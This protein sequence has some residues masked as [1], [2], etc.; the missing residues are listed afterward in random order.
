MIFGYN[1]HELIGKNVNVL[2][3]EQFRTRHNEILERVMGTG[4]FLRKVPEILSYGMNSNKEPIKLKIL[5]SMEIT[6]NSEIQITG[7]LTPAN[8][9]DES[10]YMLTDKDG[11][12]THVSA[13]L[14]T[15][16]NI[17][18]RHLQNRSFNIGY[19]N[20]LL[21]ENLPVAPIIFQKKIKIY[22]NTTI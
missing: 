1:K 12:V 17:S 5:I 9:I 13:G 14:S 19:L 8:S 16:L 3:S 2:L 7:I 11:F 22:V 21:L 6:V 4:Q 15:Q 20:I 10:G 18:Q